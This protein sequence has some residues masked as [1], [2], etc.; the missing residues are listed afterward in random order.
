MKKYGVVFTFICEIV[1]PV[2]F[3]SPIREHRILASLS[4]ML[5]ML[6]IGATGNYNFFNILTIVLLMVVL[7]DRFAFKWTPKWVW[8]V[9]DIEM[10]L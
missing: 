7:D 9:L 3:Y 5:L 2:L 8:R 10:P 1:M 6:I 4:N